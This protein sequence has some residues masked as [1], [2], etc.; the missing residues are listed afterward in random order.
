M[1]LEW[2]VCGAEFIEGDVIRWQEGVFDPGRKSGQDR[3]RV[4]NR[5]VTAQVRFDPEDPNTLLELEVRASEGTRPF[6]V[7]ELIRRA[8]RT[9]GREDTERL[10]WSD[11]EARDAVIDSLPEAQRKAMRAAQRPIDRPAAQ[12]ARYGGVRQGATG[13]PWV[14]RRRRAGGYLGRL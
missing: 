13:A 1:N 5:S 2:I 7:G 9:V 4:G 3:I 6:Q 10:E 8:R 14:T 11:E 12:P